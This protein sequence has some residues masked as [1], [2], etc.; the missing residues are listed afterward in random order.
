MHLPQI[1]RH[2]KG[3]LCCPFELAYRSGKNYILQC[4]TAIGVAM[5]LP[6]LG[7]SSLNFGP[8][9]SGLF[10]WVFSFSNTLK[11]CASSSAQASILLRL[12]YTL[13]RTSSV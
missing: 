1:T 4:N 9:F 7:V 13:L 8:L 10:S 12:K 2:K 5:L 11:G 3:Q 6:F